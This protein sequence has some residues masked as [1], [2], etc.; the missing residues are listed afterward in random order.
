MSEV[1]ESHVEEGPH[2][3]LQLDL[4]ECVHHASEPCSN[5]LV[6]DGEARVTHAKARVPM[7]GGIVLRST[8]PLDEEDFELSTR[9]FCD[10]TARLAHVH[11]GEL[12]LGLAH[13][14]VE[15]FRDGVDYLGATD[16]IEGS[17]RHVFVLA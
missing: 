16:E 15:G 11:V 8:Q 6:V 12:G 10:A 13:A 17:L 4:I 2:L 3:G 7:R 14:V 9:L 5:H 1:G